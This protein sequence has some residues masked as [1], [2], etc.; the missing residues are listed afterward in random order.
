MTPTE[1][2]KEKKKRKSPNF[3]FVAL[4]GKSYQLNHRQKKFAEAFVHFDG[5]GVEAI[6]EAGYDCNYPRSKTP[7]RKLAASMASENL[8]KPNICKYIEKIFE[9][10]GLNDAIVDKHW[11]FTLTQFSDFSAKM[12][13][14]D[15][16]NR[17]KKRYPADEHN[18]TGEIKI[19]EANA[20]KT[21]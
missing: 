6:I 21:E 9:D 10:I 13:A 18:I 4:D 19:I 8:I 17:K 2:P 20:W 15:M 5:N 11:L 16:Y 1:K 14:I 12:K 7:N 3:N